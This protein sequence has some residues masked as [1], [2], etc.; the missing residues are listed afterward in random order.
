MSYV[1]CQT[2]GFPIVLLVSSL[3]S[4]SHGAEQ[5]NTYLALALLATVSL[6]V[7]VFAL[8]RCYTQK[9]SCRGVGG[10][11]EKRCII[12]LSYL[13]KTCMYST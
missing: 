10:L 6:P 9:V 13:A 1:I 5:L 12:H 2:S 7:L 3:T 11:F 8:L 4:P